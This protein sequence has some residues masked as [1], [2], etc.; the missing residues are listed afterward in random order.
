MVR[1]IVR[2]TAL[3]GCL[4][5]VVFFLALLGVAWAVEEAEAPRSDAAPVGG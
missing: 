3:L 2:V 4:A 1:R 5:V